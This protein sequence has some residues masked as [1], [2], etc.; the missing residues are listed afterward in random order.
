MLLCTTAC[1]NTPSRQPDSV[2][3]V[4]PAVKQYPGTQQEQ[5]ATELKRCGDLCNATREFVKDFKKMRDETR[6]ALKQLT[7]KGK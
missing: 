2:R 3:L 1:T 7:N 4:L 6:L 5:V